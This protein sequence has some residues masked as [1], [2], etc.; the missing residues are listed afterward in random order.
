M[1]PEEIITAALAEAKNGSNPFQSFEGKF[2]SPE[3]YMDL[4]RIVT[5]YVTPGIFP[6]ITGDNRTK[7]LQQRLEKFRIKYLDEI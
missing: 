4:I 7:W 6:F 5:E 1:T 3:P 2:E